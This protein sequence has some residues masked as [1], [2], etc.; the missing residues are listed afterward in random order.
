MNQLTVTANANPANAN[1]AVIIGIRIED[2]INVVFGL[3][4]YSAR[5]FARKLTEMVDKLAALE[6]EK[7]KPK[8]RG[9]EPK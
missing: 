8:K 2:I 9:R 4:F 3:D 1:H 6:A 5:A 7:A